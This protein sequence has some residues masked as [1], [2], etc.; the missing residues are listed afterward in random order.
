M[1]Y[2]EKL[3][4]R[5]WYTAPFFL[6]YCFKLKDL[7]CDIRPRNI[8]W[9]VVCGFLL[10]LQYAETNMLRTSLKTLDWNSHFQVD[11]Q[12]IYFYTDYIAFIIK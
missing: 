4:G 5:E 3:Y 7:I 6:S 12:S 10:L 9:Q 8:N 11:F 2:H 1:T